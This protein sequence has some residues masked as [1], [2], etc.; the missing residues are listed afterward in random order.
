MP[1]QF[2]HPAIEAHVEAV[3]T[4]Y[5]NSLYKRLKDDFVYETEDDLEEDEAEDD[6]PSKLMID[7]YFHDGDWFVTVDDLDGPENE[8][9]Q[10]WRVVGNLEGMAFIEIC[11]EK[12]T[13]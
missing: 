9:F 6:T 13:A 1:S 4:G 2:Y 11:D 8:G 3:A 5:F 10:T 12:S 7:V